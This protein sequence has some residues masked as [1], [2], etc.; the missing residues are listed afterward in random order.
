MVI[1]STSTIAQSLSVIPRAYSGDFTMSIRDDSTNKTKVYQI[2]D[3][4]QVGNYLK[5][6]NIFNPILPENHFFDLHLYVDFS[7]WNT[8]FNLWNLDTQIWNLEDARIEDIFRDKIFCTDQDVDQLDN[9]VFY[10]LN[11]GQY[12]EY[13]GFDNTYI[14]P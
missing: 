3:A 4:L 12:V 8:N 10:K 6:T 1:L 5:F 14:V 7:V 2:A 13:N 9:N 11:K